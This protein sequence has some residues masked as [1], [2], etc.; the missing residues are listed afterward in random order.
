LEKLIVGRICIFILA[1]ERLKTRKK[2]HVLV[3]VV[4]N[5]VFMEGFVQAV[6]RTM[7]RKM[8]NNKLALAQ[9]IGTIQC[10]N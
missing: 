4:L 7:P 5:M 2:I 9:S 3:V 8:N 6:K 10:F 1:K